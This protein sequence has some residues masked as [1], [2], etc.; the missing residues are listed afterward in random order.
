MTVLEHVARLNN[1]GVWH[2][3]KDD[4]IS[5]I[6]AFQRAITLMQNITLPGCNV[7]QSPAH[8]AAMITS[9][10]RL[11]IRQSTLQLS[12]LQCG[13][14]DVY[15][16]LFRIELLPKSLARHDQCVTHEARQRFYAFVCVMDAHILFNCA[17]S[18]HHHAITIECVKSSLLS[19]HRYEMV[20]DVRNKNEDYWCNET[21]YASLFCLVLNNLASLH[22]HL[23]QYE[24]CKVCFHI[25]RILLHD[26]NGLESYLQRQEFVGLMWNTCNYQPPTVASSA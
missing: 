10:R 12:R 13:R 11:C 4:S 26:L 19:V 6:R 25:V 23:F 9:C 24:E 5:A 8:E 21:A 22:Y 7:I 2:L 18:W 3:Q 14:F 20:L 1:A 17:L 15:A 16:R